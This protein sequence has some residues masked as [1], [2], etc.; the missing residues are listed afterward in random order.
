MNKCLED[1]I[2][3]KSLSNPI[4]E[5]QSRFFDGYLEDRIYPIIIQK[6]FLVIIFG[7][8][9]S[10]NTKK[11]RHIA[12]FPNSCIREIPINNNQSPNYCLMKT[13]CLPSQ[14]VNIRQYDVVV[15]KDLEK[16][17]GG[18][19]LSGYCTCPAGQL[20]KFDITSTIKRI[21]SKIL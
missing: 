2:E 7:S 5:I 21:S 8:D 10:A 9:W 18:K 1:K 17:L 12:T 4:F 3:K 6:L 11:A 14:R 19:I 15:E 16:K 20:A 13:K